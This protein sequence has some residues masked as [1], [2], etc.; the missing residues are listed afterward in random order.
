MQ[1]HYFA[2]NILA[3]Q[4]TYKNDPNHNKNSDNGLTTTTT[5][6]SKTI[7]TEVDSHTPSQSTK[8]AI[9][10]HDFAYDVLSD[11][12][13]LCQVVSTLTTKKWMSKT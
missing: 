9:L 1:T 2:K 12:S 11:K 8:I 13:I 7:M 3:N 6:P 10:Y 5:P 4:N